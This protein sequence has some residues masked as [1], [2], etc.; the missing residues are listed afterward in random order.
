MK[1][2]LS[3]FQLCILCVDKDTK[4][5]EKNIDALPTSKACRTNTDKKREFA[6]LSTQYEQLR[7][8]RAGFS[9]VQYFDNT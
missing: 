4:V 1:S 6:S 3:N 7:I 2:F 5:F 9:V 8:K